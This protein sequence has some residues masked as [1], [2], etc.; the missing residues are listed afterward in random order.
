VSSESAQTPFRVE[1]EVLLVGREQECAGWN[2][3]RD[4][5]QRKVYRSGGLRI[6]RCWVVGYY[7]SGADA[8]D[9]KTGEIDVFQV[10]N[11][12]VSVVYELL[13]D[14]VWEGGS[15]ERCA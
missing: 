2:K 1:L 7:R 14:V 3:R 12:S 4:L 11:L 8:E 13:L 10:Y 15:F 5:K 6:F 9:C